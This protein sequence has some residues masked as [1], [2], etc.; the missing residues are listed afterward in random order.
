MGQQYRDLLRVP[1]RNYLLRSIFFRNRII[2][3]CN[4]D[5]SSFEGYQAG[6]IH[7]DPT[8]HTFQSGFKKFIV[9]LEFGKDMPI[10]EVEEFPLAVPVM[11]M[12]P[13]DDHDPDPGLETLQLLLGQDD[14]VIIINDV[15]REE[16]KVDVFQLFKT[17]EELIDVRIARMKVRVR[18]MKDLERPGKILVQGHFV[19][20][21]DEPAGFDENAVDQ[22]GDSDQDKPG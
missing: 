6:F 8:S 21:E 13:E 16:N 4:I 15:A 9:I 3:A 22:H 12:I 1:G 18:K 14:P 7:Q 2:K 19:A 11:V 17:A 5:L 10:N 20:R